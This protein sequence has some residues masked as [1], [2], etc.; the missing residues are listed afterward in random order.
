M[1]FAA[2]S[3]PL[4]SAAQ[5]NPALQMGSGLALSYRARHPN[6]HIPTADALLYPKKHPSH[7]GEVF[8]KTYHDPRVL[9]LSVDH[10]HLSLGLEEAFV[11]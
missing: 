3:W 5:G 9:H 11:F 2:G 1:H 4:M 8:V 7:L 10:L 6:T